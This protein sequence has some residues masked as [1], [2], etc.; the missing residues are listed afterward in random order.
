MAEEE[1]NIWLT[2]G[3]E[4]KGMRSLRKSGGAKRKRPAKRA[5]E[6]RHLSASEINQAWRQ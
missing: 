5:P 6:S 1:E 3:E 4:E 2:L